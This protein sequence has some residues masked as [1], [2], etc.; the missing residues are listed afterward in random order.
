MAD[1]RHAFGHPSLADED[2][3]PC[4]D[5]DHEPWPDVHMYTSEGMK[6]AA[7]WNTDTKW[8]RVVEPGGVETAVWYFRHHGLYV[9]VHESEEEAARTAVT[10]SDLGEEACVGAQLADGTVHLW[11]EWPLVKQ[12]EREDDEAWKRT[13]RE[14]RSAPRPKMVTVKCPFE[15]DGGGTADLVESEC[16][17]WL[18]E[19]S[20]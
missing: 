10:L 5:G 6:V 8:D 3:L 19:A 17:E 14:Q 9:R 20:A 11:G 12:I 4:N 1:C 15:L 13:V 16:P 7:T 2:M 18:L